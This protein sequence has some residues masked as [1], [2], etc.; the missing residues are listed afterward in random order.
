MKNES[1]EA[2]NCRVPSGGVNGLPIQQAAAKL[3]MDAFALYALIQE[4]KVN[5]NRTSG[6]SLFLAKSEMER[7]LGGL[8]DS[9][10]NKEGPC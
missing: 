8:A 2:E 3:G 1:H 6:G 7:L 5:P 9:L 10:S 4:G